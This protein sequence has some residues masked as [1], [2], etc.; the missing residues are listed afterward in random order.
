MNIKKLC[1]GVVALSLVTGAALAGSATGTSA[2]DDPGKMSPFFTDSG[3]KTMKSD[4]EIRTTWKAMRKEDRAEMIKE[5]GDAV[6]SKAHADFCKMTKQL[7][8]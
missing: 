8:E 6:M 2:L 3:M 5:C 7:G 4:K 1:T